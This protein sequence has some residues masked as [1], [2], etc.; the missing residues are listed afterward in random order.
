MFNRRLLDLSPGEVDT[1]PPAL[2]NRRACL[3]SSPRSKIGDR[4]LG[5]HFPRADRE[6]TPQTDPTMAA[7][8]PQL[9]I[10]P[11]LPARCHRFAAAA[12]LFPRRSVLLSKFGPGFHPMCVGTAH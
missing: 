6:Y 2:N 9:L 3:Y 4:T 10:S 11:C 12:C 8:A 5:T 1:F 7:L